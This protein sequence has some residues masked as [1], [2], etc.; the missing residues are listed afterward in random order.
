MIEEYAEED[1]GLEGTKRSYVVWRHTREKYQRL[2]EKK[3]QGLT[4]NFSEYRVGGEKVYSSPQLLT[5][6]QLKSLYG[7][8]Y[9]ITEHLFDGRVGEL[10]FAAFPTAQH[11]EEAQPSPYYESGPRRRRNAQRT[12]TRNLPHRIAAQ[13]EVARIE[14]ERREEHSLAE[15]LQAQL[16]RERQEAREAMERERQAMERERESERAH[17]REMME[18]RIK[19]AELEVKVATPAPQTNARDLIAKDL[20]ERTGIFEDT[21]DRIIDVRSRLEDDSEPEPWYVRAGMGL[22]EAVKPHLGDA[23]KTGMTLLASRAIQQQGRAGVPQ[24]APP[25]HT[26]NAPQPAPPVQTPAQLASTP[27]SSPSVEQPEEQTG[28]RPV[29]PPQTFEQSVDVALGNMF[30]DMDKGASV[31]A[32]SREVVAI[33]RKYPQE[34]AV[35]LGMLE[36]PT[37]VLIQLWAQQEPKVAELLNRE[38]SA[39]W[40]DKLKADI[41]RRLRS[42]KRSTT[43]PETA[44]A[45]DAQVEAAAQQG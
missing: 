43:T 34:S 45:S 23:V 27:A 5:P 19:Q 12:R 29:T 35:L 30:A 21:L 6:E 13:R 3:R 38:G 32:S 33:L 2:Y 42:T 17:N 10:T 20:L 37:P 1:V 26:M 25:A 11:V 8:G 15:V 9:Y 36:T 14:R 16:E 7:A 44:A 4:I 18:L 39:A 24:A 31:Y 41:S 22:F 40:L 28:P